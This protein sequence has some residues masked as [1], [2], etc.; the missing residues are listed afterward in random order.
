MFFKLTPYVRWT[1]AR[2]SQHCLPWQ[3]VEE[4][5]QQSVGVQGQYEKHFAQV[6]FISGIDIDL[7]RGELIGI[8]SR[9][10]LGNYSPRHSLHDYDVDATLCITL[11]TFKMVH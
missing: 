10:F 2:F 8:A 7:T 11:R 5:S 4:N 9:G 6:E 1:D 3:A